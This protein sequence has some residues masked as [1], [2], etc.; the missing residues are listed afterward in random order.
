MKTEFIAL[1]KSPES[2]PKPSL[3][4]VAF[5][6][7]SNVGKS[8]LINTLVGQKVARSSSTPGRTQGLCFFKVNP[9][10]IFVDFPG[11][12]FAKVSKQERLNWGT[13]AE[14]YFGRRLTLRGTVWVYDLRRDPD[15]LDHQ[16]REW[17][18]DHGKPFLMALTKADTLKR[19]EWFS[20]KNL[21]L[22]TLDLSEDGAV[23]FS[24]KTKEGERALFRKI[25]EEFS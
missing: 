19:S 11:Y 7:R 25:N 23:L 22:K 5:V 3:P 15:D 18:A 8:S 21:I 1:A 16:M 24:S 12:G 2:L 13:L 10:L 17:L 20:R 4:E 6:G 9:R 14:D